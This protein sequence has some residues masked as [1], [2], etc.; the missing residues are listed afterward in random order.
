MRLSGK[1][2]SILTTQLLSVSLATVMGCGKQPLNLAGSDSA[3]PPVADLEPP[4]S[5][6]RPGTEA[7]YAT[8]SL[9]LAIVS[10]SAST[11]QDTA[12]RTIDGNLASDWVA[13]NTWN[14]T[15]TFKLGDLYEIAELRIKL[16]PGF[17]TYT[18]Q[19][20]SDGSTFRT[21]ISGVRNTTWNLEAKALPAATT[22]RFVRL[23]F[24][25]SSRRVR[26]FEVQARGGAVASPTP[27]PTAA[28]STAPTLAPTPAP[29]A[30]PSPT[31]TLA[32]T[33]VPSPTPTAA[34]TLRPPI[35]GLLTNIAGWNAS[36]YL[37][38]NRT[39]RIAISPDGKRLG[40]VW[41]HNDDAANAFTGEP[42][43]YATVGDPTVPS[44][45]AAPTPVGKRPFEYA[46]GIT[47]EYKAYN[48][49][50]NEGFIVAKPDG[51]FL[52]LSVPMNANGWAEMLPATGYGYVLSEYAGGMWSAPGLA[53]LRTTSLGSSNS[54]M[55]GNADGDGN[56]HIFGQGHLG[57]FQGGM[58]YQRRNAGDTLWDTVNL[59]AAWRSSTEI[60]YF[61]EGWG[62]VSPRRNALGKFDLH[63]A[64]AW[65]RRGWE[66]E[67]YGLY[68]LLSQDGGRTWLNVNKQV[69]TLP[70][71]VNTN[72]GP[73]AVFPAN[74]S[75]TSFTGNQKGARSISVTAGPD[76][77]PLIVRST[78]VSTTTVQNRLYTYVNGSWIS[79]PVGGPLF[80]N[81]NRTHVSYN[82]RTGKVNVI[83]LDPGSTSAP[84]RVLLFSQPLSD[85][86]AGKSAWTQEV[87]A[88]A[89]NTRNYSSSLQVV[90]VP[91]TRFEIMFEPSYAN[92][93]RVSPVFAEAAMR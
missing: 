19:V 10:V 90:E 78:Y 22:G 82:R 80:W 66:S 61:V 26:V 92:P 39:A 63:V 93:G 57:G 28:P 35:S 88:Q 16:D 21:V 8:A 59:A 3:M 15:L 65:N 5:G 67:M 43:A 34:P 71:K 79:V 24:N 14:P 36:T 41:Q 68:Y 46:A 31:P 64:F 9:P 33:P 38:Q 50:H 48:V 42:H 55:S 53:K 86:R 87:V 51:G 2:A 20:S 11:Q 76:G 60:I 89:T 74:V 49:Q 72:D 75:G 54:E 62:Y 12:Y 40:V 32:P 56:I 23:I 47:D 7:S 17:G 69:Q 30:V 13:R 27:A 83:L 73:A 52:T 37:P 91:D 85:V 77:E 84:G 45:F 44:S 18:I 6:E 4:A 70:L 1:R 25:N 29:T 81:F 58:G